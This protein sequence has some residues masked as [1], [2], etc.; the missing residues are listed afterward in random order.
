MGVGG[1]TIEAAWEDR[2][3]KLGV[4]NSKTC[5]VIRRQAIRKTLELSNVI[6]RQFHVAM[7]TSPEWALQ[8]LSND[9]SNTTN[10][11][12]KLYIIFMGPMSG[13]Q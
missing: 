3:T 2:L 5:D 12:F 11:Q 6:L 1:S 13:L 8:A 4:N 9:I 7:H 10:E